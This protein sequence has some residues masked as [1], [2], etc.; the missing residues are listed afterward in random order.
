MNYRIV[1]TPDFDRKLKKI[2]KKHKGIKAD[3]AK[4][5]NLLKTEPTMGDDLGGNLYKIRLSI[6]NTNKGK[7]GG[8]RVITFVVF[9]EEVVYLA[10]IYLKSDVDTVDV[11]VINQ[12][13]KNDGLR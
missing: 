10:D 3:L 12:H 7:S 4:L 8:A 2:V 6:A 13:L 1:A 11:K 9:V 5:I